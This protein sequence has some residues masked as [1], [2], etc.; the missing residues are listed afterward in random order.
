MV[1]EWQ[2][3]EESPWRLWCDVGVIAMVVE[4][5]HEAHGTIY[6]W[7]VAD[8]CG[9]GAS[10]REA[11]EMAEDAARRLLIA[12]LVEV[13]NRSPAPFMVILDRYASLPGRLLAQDVRVGSP[14]PFFA[15]DPDDAE[16]LALELLCASSQ[17]RLKIGAQ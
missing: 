6:S 16:G 13:P 2:R 12:S 9:A 5:R 10:E 14:P 7:C 11:Q 1:V 8:E 17:V 3:D 15:M 4:A